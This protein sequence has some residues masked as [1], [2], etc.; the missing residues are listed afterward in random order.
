MTEVQELCYEVIKLEV[1]HYFHNKIF[2]L[3][4]SYELYSNKK[5]KIFL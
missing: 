4:H 5:V 3:Q 1:E 2:D